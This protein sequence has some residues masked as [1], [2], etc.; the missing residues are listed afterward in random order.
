V[1]GTPPYFYQWRNGGVNLSNGGVYS[2]VFTN[3]LAL[4]SV[5]TNNSGNYSV[6]ITNVAG[7]VTSSV[8]SLTVGSL[9]QLMITAGSPGNF[10]FNANTITDLTY[11]VLMTTNLAAP[12][13]TSVATNNTGAGGAINYQTNTANGPNQFYRLEFP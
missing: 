12:S 1:T 9:P 7:S 3:T 10:Q 11:V 6:A 4:T 5:T 2:G 8:T 13:W